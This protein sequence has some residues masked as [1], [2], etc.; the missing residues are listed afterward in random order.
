MKLVYVN[1][2]REL[3]NFGCRT[4]GPALEEIL[5]RRHEIIRRSG[6][7]TVYGSGWDT[8]APG[9][10]RS[11]GLLPARVYRV[12]W[13]RRFSSPALFRRYDRVDGWLGAQHDYIREDPEESVTR[14][15]RFAEHDAT[16]ASLMRALAESDGVVINGEGTLI[17]G[18]PTRRDAL[19]LLFILSLAKK[20]G[21][22]AYLLN[23]MVAPCPYDGP[24][25]RVLERSVPLLRHCD[26]VVC[27]EQASFAFVKSIAG[28]ANLA[29]LPDALFSWGERFRAAAA[30][31]K[32]LP[33]LCWGFRSRIDARRLDLSAP[34]VCISGS[35]SAWRAGG[36]AS[37]GLA[38]LAAAVGKL[39]V[40]V[41]LVETCDGDAYLREVA[42]RCD[43]PIVPS[44]TPVMAA[45][46]IFAGAEAYIS[47][48]YHPAIMASAGG[49]PCVF[50]RSNSH[51][52]R[53]L[54]TTLGYERSVEFST[55][56]DAG[57]VDAIVAEIQ[58]CLSRRNELSQRIRLTYDRLALQLNQYDQLV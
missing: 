24:D 4:T 28:D 14:F 57:E 1:D 46:G 35:S 26:R 54:Q 40:R 50:Q 13:R 15:K 49:V 10:I 2:L 17:F 41:I 29:C 45:A 56:P 8:Y 31:V 9:P 20:L 7:E 55:C 33:Q 34:Y 30:A 22:R 6:L 43:L 27:R 12:L 32:A 21:K 25:P 38:R 53:E 18:N 47:G 36:S 19:Y 58:S 48:R 44:D 37:D 5:S 3:P 42:V 52:T 16:A 51:K 39:G 23:A 11:G